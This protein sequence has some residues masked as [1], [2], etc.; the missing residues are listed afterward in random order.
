MSASLLVIRDNR[1]NVLLHAVS[2][3]C[4][5]LPAHYA[6]AVPLPPAGIVLAPSGRRDW[7]GEAKSSGNQVALIISTTME[8]HAFVTSTERRDGFILEY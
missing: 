2:L 5:A 1:I 4:A 6:L 8:L 3:Y 7:K